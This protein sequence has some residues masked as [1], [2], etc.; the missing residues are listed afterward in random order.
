MRLRIGSL[1]AAATAALAI[2]GCNTSNASKLDPAGAVPAN[3]TMFASAVIQPD[4][5]QVATLKRIVDQFGG[6]RA[7]HELLAPAEQ[8]LARHGAVLAQIQPWLGQRIGLAF[9]TLPVATHRQVPPGL[10]LIIPTNDPAGAR[11]WAAAAHKQRANRG[12]ASAVHGNYLLL[13]SPGA[14]RQ[15]SSYHGRTLKGTPAWQR[16]SADAPGAL[17]SVYLQVHRAL[18]SLVGNRA[19][20]SFVH[21]VPFLRDLSKLPRSAV[22]GGA[23]TVGDAHI[24][25]DA[26]T[27]GIRRSGGS[28]A[29]D[30]G[31]LPA[32]S[33][34][35]VA[36][37]LSREDVLDYFSVF[38]GLA[39]G[40]PGTESGW[41]SYP[42][43]SST[44]YAPSIRAHLLQ[45]VDTLDSALGALGPLKFAFSG[46]SLAGLH[47]G[48]S[49]SPHNQAD[50]HRVLTLLRHAAAKRRSD[51]LK[52]S[53]HG[54]SLTLPHHLR[55]SVNHVAHKILALLG[56][57]HAAEFLHASLTLN[58]D[59]QYRAAAGTL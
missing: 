2:A 59:A 46:G 58:S 5:H 51:H 4:D 37:K 47:A 15:V 45:P 31:S 38:S 19:T 42:P 32:N 24:A 34:G 8:A 41:W 48:L 56:F 6:T 1:I 40:L 14:V 18:G 52:S 23:L 25:V 39:L 9:T 7:W 16:I 36:L 26:I 44:S 30:V 33:T 21:D 13:G 53:P 35:A 54:F 3:V 43:A 49:V 28:A 20:R 12:W 50:A 22:L 57:R 29:S 11:K 55:V 17:A 10:V 27:Y